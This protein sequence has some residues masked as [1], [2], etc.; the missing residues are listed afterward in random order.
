MPPR[1][2]EDQLDKW[3]AMETEYG[4]AVQQFVRVKRSSATIRIDAL[5]LVQVRARADKHRDRYF[6]M[7]LPAQ[8]R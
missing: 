3:L 2:A 7:V 5:S 6:K 4:Q 1:S 8:R